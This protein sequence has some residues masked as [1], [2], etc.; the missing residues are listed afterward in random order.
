MR[1]GDAG[2]TTPLRAQIGIPIEGVERLLEY[3]QLYAQNPAL[4]PGELLPP[5]VND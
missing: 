3:W 1:E 2:V 4:F 5:S